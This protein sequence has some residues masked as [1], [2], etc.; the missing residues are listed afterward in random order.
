MQDNQ[1]DIGVSGEYVRNQKLS[2]GTNLFKITGPGSLQGSDAADALVAAFGDTKACDDTFTVIPFQV[3]PAQPA[4][5]PLT[6]IGAVVLV[7]GI[8][9]WKRQ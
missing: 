1:F 5:L 9:L 7:L 3:S 6:L 8:V 2:N 4:L